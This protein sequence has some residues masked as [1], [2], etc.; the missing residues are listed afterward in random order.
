MITSYMTVVKYQNREIS[1]GI[2]HR[3]TQ[4]STVL[5]ALMCVCVCM[6]FCAVL[7]HGWTHITTTMIETQSCFFTT[8]IPVLCL[9]GHKLFQF[10]PPSPGNH[11]LFQHLYN[12]VIYN[13]VTLRMLQKWNHTMF[14]HSMMYTFNIQ[15]INF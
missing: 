7:S 10:L 12:F 15:C 2:I 1:L 9:Y 11:Y 13:F 3:P 14:K 6:K 5:H 4:I 8:R